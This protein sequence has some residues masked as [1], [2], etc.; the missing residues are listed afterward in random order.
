[1]VGLVGRALEGSRCYG[2]RLILSSPKCDLFFGVS[3]PEVSRVT[4]LPKSQNDY[5]PRPRDTKVPARNRPETALQK[6]REEPSE[7][8]KKRNNNSMQH[9]QRNNE[10]AGNI[11][12]REDAQSKELHELG[13]FKRV[14]ILPVHILPVH[15]LPVQF[16]QKVACDWV[17]KFMGQ[18]RQKTFLGKA[19]LPSGRYNIPVP[20]FRCAPKLTRD[21]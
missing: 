6:E 18:T 15:I 7:S 19:R 5:N 4:P 12:A 17:A 13:V 8:R 14:H 9:D 2:D 16:D 1:M 21:L 11:G 3:E 10:H 20:V